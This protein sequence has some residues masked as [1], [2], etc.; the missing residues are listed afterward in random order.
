MSDATRQLT[1]RNCFSVRNSAKVLP[2]SQLKFRTFEGQW[3]IEFSEFPV[4]VGAQ[5][6]NRFDEGRPILLPVGLRA[7]GT[8]AQSKTDQP[9]SAFIRGKQHH[10]QRSVAVCVPDLLHSGE[11]SIISHLIE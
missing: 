8:F 4:K 6:A 11:M 5:L 1:V 2:H 3:Q 9:K 10:A 7:L